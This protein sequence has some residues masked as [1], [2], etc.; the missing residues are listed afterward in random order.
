MAHPKKFLGG[1]WPTQ[2]TVWRPP[3]WGGEEERVGF[4]VQKGEGGRERSGGEG[5]SVPVWEKN[6]LVILNAIR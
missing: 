5:R 6:N 1:P 2:N 3:W 4:N